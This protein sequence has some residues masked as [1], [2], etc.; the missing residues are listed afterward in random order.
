MTLWLG[1]MRL[2][3]RSGWS[4]TR[5]VLRP[6]LRRLFPDVPDDHPPSVPWCSTLRPTCR[7]DQFPQRPGTARH[8]IFES[9]TEP[10]AQ[11]LN[12]MCTFLAINT[13]S[14]AIAARVRH[15]LV[16]RGRLAGSAAIVGTTLLATTCSS[17]AGLIAVKT[18]ER[19]RFFAVDRGGPMPVGP[20]PTRAAEPSEQNGTPTIPE[21]APITL[22]GRALLIAFAASFALVCTSP[23][24]RSS[25]DPASSL[26]V[27][28]IQALSTLAIP[29]LVA[30]FPAARGRPRVGVYEGVCGRA[31]KVGVAVKSSPPRGHAGG[32]RHAPRCGECWNCWSA[33]RPRR[34]PPLG[35]PSQLLPLA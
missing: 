28:T 16:R 26:A 4:R 17:I 13:G 32:D 34:C 18:L 3:E 7:T 9:S 30:G 11:P 14:G 12:A 1:L 5:P 19:L 10:R 21:L 23:R 22:R 24:D 27:R 33:G 31:L 20:T 29:L 15:R 35:I 2:V 25:A 6:L 8:G